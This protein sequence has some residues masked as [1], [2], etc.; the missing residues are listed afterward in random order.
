MGT[1]IIIF[2]ILAIISFLCAWLLDYNP[3]IIIGTAIGLVIATI[4]T[5]IIW[6]FNDEIPV[7]EVYR[8]NTTL[9][10]TY[11]DSVPIDSVVV[12]KNK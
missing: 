6:H 7:I 2:I 10:I 1:L 4:I 8:G 9:Q 5:A 12:Y 11:Q 3:D